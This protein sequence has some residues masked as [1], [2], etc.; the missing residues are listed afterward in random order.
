MGGGQAGQTRGGQNSGGT[1]VVRASL[2]TPTPPWPVSTWSTISYP[3]EWRAPHIFSPLLRLHRG[4]TLSVGQQGTVLPSG[5]RGVTFCIFKNIKEGWFDQ[6]PHSQQIPRA[7]RPS[8]RGSSGEPSP[9]QA[10][11]ERSVCIKDGCSP[12][13]L[14]L[15]APSSQ[16]EK[17]SR[18]CLNTRGRH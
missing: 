3:R 6:T 17:G 7:T 2:P 12:G 14:K 4:D 9:L 1:S 5:R 11:T 18:C 10:R 15:H 8:F 16:D 13:G